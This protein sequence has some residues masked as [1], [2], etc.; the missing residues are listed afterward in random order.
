[1]RCQ[2]ALTGDVPATGDSRGHH[3]APADIPFFHLKEEK[4]MRASEQH[5]VY[6]SGQPSF[7][8]RPG[9]ITGCG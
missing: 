6:R 8:A 1:M 4:K 7:R 9:G 3:H 5:P 2:Q